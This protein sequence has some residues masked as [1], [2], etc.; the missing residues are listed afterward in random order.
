VEF[1][2]KRENKRHIE[3]TKQSTSYYFFKTGTEEFF[4]IRRG[5][6]SLA[7]KRKGTIL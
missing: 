5:T 4:C 1:T 7:M 2:G 3:I 6:R